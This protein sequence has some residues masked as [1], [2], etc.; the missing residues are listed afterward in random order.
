M[1]IW[2]MLAAMIAGAPAQ[3]KVVSS[4]AN[5]FEISHGFETGMTANEIYALFG[6]PSRWWSSDHTYSGD[7]RRLKMTLQPGGCFCETLP[8]G[9]GIH[10]L[11]VTYVDPG[12]RVVL[13]GGLGPLLYE[14]VA[15]VMDVQIKPRAAGGSTIILNYRASGFAK[16]GADKL[17]PLVDSVLGSQM[18]RL[19]AVARK[20]R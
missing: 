1:K 14:A 16:G 8:N 6:Q 18:T 9:G 20:Q 4:S 5:G 3:A 2:M 10:H 13:E 17:A 7:A 19:A 12:K 15:G 11:R